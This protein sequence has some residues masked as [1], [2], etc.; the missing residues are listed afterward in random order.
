MM[1]APEFIQLGVWRVRTS[2]I[3]RYFPAGENTISV[4]YTTNK[5][6]IDREWITFSSQ[7][8]RDRAL[9]TLDEIFGIIHKI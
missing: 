2:I 6:Q 5:T 4:F 8:E 1:K 3:K 9:E 7:I